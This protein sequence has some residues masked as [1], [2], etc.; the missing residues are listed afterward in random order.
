MGS[1]ANSISAPNAQEP[2]THARLTIPGVQPQRGN[3]PGVWS[4][5]PVYKQLDPEFLQRPLIPR[6]PPTPRLS[7][8]RVNGSLR[9]IDQVNTP[10]I[11]DVPDTVSLPIRVHTP[12][13]PLTPKS[14]RSL[15]LFAVLAGFVAGLVAALL[16]G[17]L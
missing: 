2:I 13:P 9:I 6:A 8:D 5:G 15:Q 1:L 12:L 16:L 10:A 4:Q 7:I 14:N 17:W 3:R 11:T